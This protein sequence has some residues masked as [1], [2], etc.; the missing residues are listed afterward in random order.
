MAPRVEW[1]RGGAGYAFCR[2]IR[3]NQGGLELP[4]TFARRNCESPTP[5]RNFFDAV[6]T[7]TE[8]I[9]RTLSG[10]GIDH[11]EVALAFHLRMAATPIFMHVYIQRQ[12]PRPTRHRR[13]LQ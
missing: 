2:A 9:A 1:V 8:N 6:E 7:K 3:E 5:V 13:R 11:S 4:C 12:P 10:R